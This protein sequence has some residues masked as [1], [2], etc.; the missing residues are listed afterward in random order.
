MP[1]RIE[2]TLRSLQLDVDRAPLP[3][4]GSVR[5]QGDRRTRNQVVASA[6]VT[7]AFVA[8]AVGVGA[9]LVGD[10]EAIEGPP[11]P[12]PTVSTTQ[13]PTLSLAAAP[14]LQDGDLTGVGPYGDFQDSGDQPSYQLMQCIDVAALAGTATLTS[15][16]L[17]EPDIGEPTVHEHAL[18]FGSAAAADEF[19]TRAGQAFATCEE[20]DPAEVTVTDRGPEQVAGVEGLRGSRLTVPTADAGIG[21]YELGVVREGNVVVALE[22]SSMGN[23]YGD[24]SGDWVLTPERLQTAIDRAVG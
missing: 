6:F 2:E 14:F 24:E 17:F 7:V 18:E 16:V 13:E 1:D 4:S 12:Q 21:Y 22:W 15:T 19:V 23:P 5:R 9:N 20:G 8:A 11:A 3:D 10:R